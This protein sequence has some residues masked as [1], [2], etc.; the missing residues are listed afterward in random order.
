MYKRQGLVR[1]LHAVSAAWN[2]I[3]GYLESLLDAAGRRLGQVG[4]QYFGART[5]GDRQVNGVFARAWP[6]GTAALWIAVLLTAYVF[7]YYLA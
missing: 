2:R 6:I 5:E 1:L 7:F 3:A 4:R